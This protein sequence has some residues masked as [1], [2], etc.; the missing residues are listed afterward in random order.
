MSYVQGPP[1]GQQI[2]QRVFKNK[3]ENCEVEPLWSAAALMSFWYWLGANSSQVQ[4]LASA[5]A[6]VVA[7]IV[8][9]V[10]WKQKQAAEAQAK[11]ANEQTTAAKEQADAAKQQVAAAKQQ[12]ATSLLIADRQ[13]SP[14]ISITA[15]G[16]LPFD[17][18]ASI[19]QTIAILNNGSGP[20]LNLELKYKDGLPGDDS[21]GIAGKVLVV[22]DSLSVL[23]DEKRAAQSGL[24]LTDETIFGTKCTLE[25]QWNSEVGK[26]VNQKL[27]TAP[28]N[29]V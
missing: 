15:G 26:A 5:V 12:T 17:A 1:P 21:F 14:N 20:A 18:G 9:W 8:G 4:A 16:I 25:F 22:R 10:V 27:F 11:A 13:V 23:V 19:R 24:R 7:A 2:S 6:V 29:H 28:A 3:N